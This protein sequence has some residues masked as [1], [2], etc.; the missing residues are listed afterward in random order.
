MHRTCLR[1]Q[2]AVFKQEVCDRYFSPVHQIA[3]STMPWLSNCKSLQDYVPTCY[4]RSLDL[5]Q[6]GS[7]KTE[8]QSLT[9][10]KSSIDIHRLPFALAKF[11]LALSCKAVTKVITG[12]TSAFQHSFTFSMPKRRSLTYGDLNFK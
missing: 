4:G 12:W 10:N 1:G 6:C 3:P 8:A 2:K 11:I 9:K 7:S 5:W